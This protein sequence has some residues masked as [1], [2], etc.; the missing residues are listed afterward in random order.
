MIDNAIVSTDNEQIATVAKEYN[1]NVPFK[2]PDELA[3]D[4]A[5]TNEVITHAIEWATEEY[6]NVDYVSLLQVTSPLREPEDIDNALHRLQETSSQSVVSVSEYLSPP[7][8]AVAEDN[9]GYLESQSD[10]AGLWQ[11]EYV[12]SQDLGTLLHPNGA[13]SAATIDAW[14]EFESF[15]TPETVGYEMPAKRS[16]DIDEPWELELVRKMIHT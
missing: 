1:G 6:S 7:Q 3:T 10:S 13:V 16:L 15:Y 8:W 14:T 11:D 5:P 4:K 12:R 2:R 9:D